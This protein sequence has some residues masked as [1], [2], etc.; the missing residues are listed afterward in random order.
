M[1]H[2][3]QTKLFLNNQRT[4]QANIRDQTSGIMG[5]VL[6]VSVPSAHSD[7]LSSVPAR[8]YI[9]VREVK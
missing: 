4:Q 5:R 2:F 9:Y 1:S 7:N 3:A 8:F 6:V